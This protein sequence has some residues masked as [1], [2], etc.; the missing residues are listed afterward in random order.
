M[1]L[2]LEED[3]EGLYPKEREEGSTL[4]GGGMGVGFCVT[5]RRRQGLTRHTSSTSLW[6]GE[7]AL[8]AGKKR[9][10]ACVGEACE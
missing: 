5:P 3:D 6:W 10:Q 1:A 4:G 8:S 7:K 9:R 2:C